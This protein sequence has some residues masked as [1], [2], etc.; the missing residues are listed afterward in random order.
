MIHKDGEIKDVLVLAFLKEGLAK[1]NSDLIRQQQEIAMT[2]LA[3]RHDIIARK[4]AY[5]LFI[6]LE[7]AISTDYSGP[8]FLY[9]QSIFQGRTYLEKN[10]ADMNFGKKYP[11]LSK[12]VFEYLKSRLEREK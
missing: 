1:R 6:M 4:K 9:R 12:R 3:R 2:L 10:V 5:R 8:T 11:R 7:K